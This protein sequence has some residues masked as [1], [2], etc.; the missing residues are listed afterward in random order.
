MT[1]S[2]ERVPQILHGA[3]DMHL[4]TAPDIIKRKYTDIELAEHGR[5]TGLAG[6]V[7]KNHHVDTA[8]R[9]AIANQVIAGIRL[10]G[11]VALN[12]SVGGLN[13]YAVETS[14]KLGG[15]V[16]WMPTVDAAN[17]HQRLGQQGGISILA[18][19][20]KLKPGV[21][22]IIDLVKRYHAVLATGHLGLE[23]TMELVGAATRSRLGKI[24]VTHP[25]FWITAMPVDMQCAL[26]RKGV[27]FERCF[28]ASTLKND[29]T[30]PFETTIGWIKRVGIESTVIASDLGQFDSPSPAEGLSIML[31]SLLHNGF[32]AE[33][34]E[35]MIKKNPAFLLSS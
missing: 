18:D 35:V 4:H 20:G 3:I 22:D 11:G 32:S 30:T 5:D 25:E 14:L 24:V 29:K 6:M 31:T 12:L 23:E 28:Y 26:S 9:A 34:I 8:G 2:P 21:F 1:N 13:P 7:V 15:R 16:V 10:Y 19:S 17:H 27:F 33:Q